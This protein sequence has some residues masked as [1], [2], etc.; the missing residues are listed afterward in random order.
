MGTTDWDAVPSDIQHYVLVLSGSPN[1]CCLI[2]ASCISQW[3]PENVTL[4]LRRRQG[5]ILQNMQA[6]H[7]A[8]KLNRLDICKAVMSVQQI[9]RPR[10]GSGENSAL[11]VA[12]AHG[13][14]RICEYLLHL[15]AAARP[16]FKVGRDPLIEAIKHGHLEVLLLLFKYRPAVEVDTPF[17][18]MLFVYAACN[19]WPACHVIVQTAKT[20]Y[21]GH[22]DVRE[23]LRNAVEARDLELL[24]YL[25]TFHMDNQQEGNLWS[26]LYGTQSLL[27]AAVHVG[28]RKI[29]G[30]ILEGCGALA[31]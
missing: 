20:F 16:G 26:A 9:R 14:L 24:S 5:S 21:L 1:V 30:F 29:V 18:Q 22:A 19:A 27:L 31:G 3:E 23:C 6:L 17:M 13:R 11:C 12:A 10:L 15:G 25:L 7:A 2:K 28:D 8:I 4:W